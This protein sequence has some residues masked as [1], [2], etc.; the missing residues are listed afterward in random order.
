MME[1]IVP[2]CCLIIHLLFCGMI[3]LA[4]RLHWLQL[5]GVYLPVILL[6]PFWGVL[7]VLLLNWKAVS[8]TDESLE[9]DRG[10][11]WSNQG[12][13]ENIFKKQERGDD[14]LV[15]LEEAL[16]L[17]S[18]VQRR[19][20]MMDVLY[21]DPEEYID[22]LYEARL[23]DDVEV[24]HYATTAMA[25]I[26]KKYD[27]ALQKAEHD[28]AKDPGNPVTLNRYCDLLEKYISLG[29]VQ[30][31]PLVIQRN[32]FEQLLEKK[33]ETDMGCENWL[34]KA[35]NELELREFGK[36]AESLRMLERLFPDEP[37]AWMLKLKFYV[38]QHEG[39]KIQRLIAEMESRHLY[40]SKEDQEMIE[41]WKQEGNVMAGAI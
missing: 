1:G 15:P 23:N 20:L 9:I 26:S 24:V 17:N 25:E 11:A 38:L 33:L 18:P 2:G 4:Y 27:L 29:I 7:C 39:R 5:K 34:K 21:D 32:Q 36:A 16:I 37:K 10:E 31:Q 41:F 28:Y 22:L 3:Y 40:F 14:G 6:V 8:H 19:K 12:I 30:G 13:Y 35:E